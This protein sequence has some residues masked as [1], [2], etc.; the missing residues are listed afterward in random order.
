MEQAVLIVDD[1]V[2]ILFYLKEQLKKFFGP[3]Y[4]YETAIN[5]NEAWEI[6]NELI[7]NNINLIL[8]VSDWLLPDTHGDRFLIDIQNKFPSVKKIL[9]TGHACPQDIFEIQKK[10]QMEGFLTKPWR[11]EDLFFLLKKTTNTL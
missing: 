10:V 3:N 5:V 6:I 9:I 4:R 8:V 7:K 2:L 11:E 1:E